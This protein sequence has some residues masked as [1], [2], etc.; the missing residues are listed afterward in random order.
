MARRPSTGWRTRGQ[1][2]RRHDNNTVHLGHAAVRRRRMPLSSRKT[3]NPARPL[4]EA[5]G[6][7]QRSQ[8]DPRGRLG[9][10]SVRTPTR[11]VS[12]LPPPS[13]AL[14]IQTANGLRQKPGSEPWRR[15]KAPKGLDKNIARR[16]SVLRPQ[17]LVAGRPMEWSA[18]ARRRRTLAR[19]K[20]RT[21]PAHRARRSQ[22]GAVHAAPRH[23]VE[24]SALDS[25]FSGP[26]S[27]RPRKGPRIFHFPT[28][29]GHACVKL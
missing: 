14:R 29:P 9:N 21:R 15:S 27:R 20:A 12:T 18:R 4:G 23:W 6:G 8:E 7:A 2:R 28:R 16:L 11:K 5:A 22:L 1:S 3:K 10:R 17:L 26:N 25:K 19:R 24:P 13:H